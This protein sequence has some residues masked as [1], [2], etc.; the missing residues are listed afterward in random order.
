[1]EGRGDIVA[2]NV[3]LVAILGTYE[4]EQT[5]DRDDEDNAAGASPRADNLWGAMMR[6]DERE[7]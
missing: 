6:D 1:M 5:L 3:A 4:D 7:E 2:C